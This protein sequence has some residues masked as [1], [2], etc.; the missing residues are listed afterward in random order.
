MIDLARSDGSSRAGARGCEAGQC[1]QQAVLKVRVA[2]CRVR[3]AEPLVVPVF[4]AAARLGFVTGGKPFLSEVPEP[5][6]VGSTRSAHS[7]GHP[8]G[9]DG[10]AV[11]IGPDA[12]DSD[13]ES[14]DEQ[15]AV[16]VRAGPASSAP[17]HAGH[18][19]SPPVV[20]AA[21]EVYEPVRAIDEGGKHV[22]SDDVDRHDLPA[23]VDAGVVDHRVN[24]AELVDLVGQSPCLVQV[25]QIPDDG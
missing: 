3:G 24:P 11:H 13:G 6:V 9:V 15:L 10:I 1:V 25:G 7:G 23:A 20:H 19:G 21:A 16:R 14:G 2:G 22:R 17:V 12:S 5:E 18:I 4:A 8:A